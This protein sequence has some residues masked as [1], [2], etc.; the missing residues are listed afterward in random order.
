MFDSTRTWGSGDPDSGRPSRQL[1]PTR[2]L[3]ALLLVGGVWS[4]TGAVGEADEPPR[5]VEY[6]VSPGDT[7]WELAAEIAPPGEDVRRWVTLIKQLN[8]L[9]GSDLRVG[10]RL[11][12]PAD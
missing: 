7:L 3:A 9:T 12:L 6:V 2:L 8:G 1:L 10:Q 4:A 5:T 11:V